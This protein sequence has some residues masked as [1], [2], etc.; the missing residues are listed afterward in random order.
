[1][2][3]INH[4]LATLVARPWINRSPASVGSTPSLNHRK[5]VLKSY[6]HRL[7][8]LYPKCTVLGI[9]GLWILGEYADFQ[10]ILTFLSKQFRLL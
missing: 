2:H 5:I 4:G 9:R 7:L 8:V 3:G 6:L 10:P 1:M